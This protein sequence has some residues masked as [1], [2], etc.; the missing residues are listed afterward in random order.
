MADFEAMED[1]A[2]P[3]IER[4]LAAFMR[5]MLTQYEATDAVGMPEN[6]QARTLDMLRDTYSVGVRMA[7]PPVID[8]EKGC[9]THLQTK[10]D[11][12]DLFQQFVAEF[13]EQFGAAR[14]TQILS[15]TRQQ[16]MELIRD[17]QVDGLGVDQI[18][19]NIREAIP[20][21]SAYRSRVIARTET[22]SSS[23]YGVYRTAL[24]SRRPLNKVWSSIQDPRTRSFM[25]DD[26]YDH[27]DM[28]G[29]TVP[30]SMPFMVPTIYGT[31]EPLMYPG[32]PNGTPGNIINCRCSMTFKRVRGA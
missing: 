9:F 16:I 28:D 14:V 5:E 26:T 4:T 21:L 10:Q 23:Q 6:A 20:N 25:N 24:T 29:Q 17:G 18:A 30:M 15:T 31:K 11:E 32:D 1:A 7:G 19:R 27:R 8:D 12:D 2:A 13:I 22:H 3:M